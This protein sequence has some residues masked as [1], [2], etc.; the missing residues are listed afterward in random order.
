MQHT[1]NGTP[2]P[3]QRAG[4][5]TC[6]QDKR[7]H[8]QNIPRR[9]LPFLLNSVWIRQ[10]IEAYNATI[11]PCVCIW[12]IPCGVRRRSVCRFMEPLVVTPLVLWRVPLWCSTNSRSPRSNSGQSIKSFESLKFKL[13]HDSKRTKNALKTANFLWSVVNHRMRREIG[14]LDHRNSQRWQNHF[15]KRKKMKREIWNAKG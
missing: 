9:F 11:Q 7:F 8:N 3:E 1:T 4:A 5:R 12:G 2:V 13:A 14:P 6:C 15:E 10:M